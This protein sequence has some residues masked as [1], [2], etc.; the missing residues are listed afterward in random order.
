MELD[1]AAAPGVGQLIINN[2]NS[3]ATVIVGGIKVSRA[4]ITLAK[5]RTSSSQTHYIRY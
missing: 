1:G 3:S 5:K 4:S 2:Q